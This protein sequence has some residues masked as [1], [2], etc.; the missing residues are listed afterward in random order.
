MTS[1]ELKEYQSKAVTDLIDDCEELLDD[2]VNNNER[3]KHLFF[4]PTGSGKTVVCGE[5]VR[6]WMDNTNHNCSFIWIAP[7]R[8]HNQSHVKLKNQL[9]D[10][11][12]KC[13]NLFY[14]R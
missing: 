12:I 11:K 2:A 3:K 1:I 13:L 4:A 9:K 10:S 14:R 7:N 8:L 5:F 6:E